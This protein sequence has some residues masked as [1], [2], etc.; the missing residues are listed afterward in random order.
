MALLV[1]CWASPSAA[2][3][4]WKDLEPG[5]H[6]VGY[7]VVRQYDRSRTFGGVAADRLIEL[8]IW[9]PAAPSSGATPMTY[10]AYRD[11]DPAD[12]PTGAFTDT[13]RLRTE[14]DI[15]LAGMRF[16]RDSVEPPAKLLA[17]RTGAVRNAP[18]RPGPFPAIVYAPGRN[19]SSDDNVV[20]FEYLASH[21]YV[22][23]AIASQGLNT[24]TVGQGAGTVEAGV[25]DLEF[26]L[27]YLLGTPEV[28]GA[29]VGAA[30]FSFGGTWA[31]LLAMRNARVRGVVALDPSFTFPRGDGV[32]RASP[33]FDS[34]RFTTP[35]LVAA[36]RGDEWS[37]LAIDALRS[38]PRF[39][40]R[41]AGMSHSD[42]CS[43][44]IA[45]RNVLG[46]AARDPIIRHKVAGYIGVATYVREFLDAF[47]K[48]DSAQAMAV[49][50]K[51]RWRG[52]GSDDVEFTFRLGAPQV[53]MFY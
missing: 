40:L 44:G 26:A 1:S 3:W 7:R 10:A 51:P 52:V 25:R 14:R 8:R 32:I 49:R 43:Y 4:P 2:Q 9:Y 31:L 48:G 41:V 12:G 53:P 33:S 46:A 5:A 16:A 50:S 11:V 34:T 28:D 35:L 39:T 42:F 20:L 47:V 23:G 15:K 45:Y 29:R 17:S 30:G 36:Q 22:V 21:G 37:S 38:A 13:M 27:A 24:V 18:A 6:P 19:D